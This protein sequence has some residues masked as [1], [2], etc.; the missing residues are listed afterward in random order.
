[1]IDIEITCPK[2]ETKFIMKVYKLGV[3]F[4]CPCPKCETKIKIPEAKKC[5]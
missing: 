5:Q 3:F 2:C 1:M 4:Q